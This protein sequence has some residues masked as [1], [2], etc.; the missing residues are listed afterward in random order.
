[1]HEGHRKR[2]L[3][4]LESSADSLQDHE[5][6]E[7]LLYLEVPRKNTNPLAH[8]L[9]SS[10]GS[11]DGV[12]HATYEQL[13]QVEGVGPETAAFLRCNAILNER[14][15]FNEDYF[16]KKFNFENYA[17]F[18]K[19]RFD[20]VT[21]EVVEVFAL[22]SSEHVISCKRFTS[23]SIDKASVD[24]NDLALLIS[25]HRPHGIVLAHNHPNAPCKSSSADDGFTARVAMLC[26]VQNIQLFDHMIVGNDGVYSY[27]LSRDLDA[28]KSAFHIETMMKE[29]QKS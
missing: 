28:F 12:F 10:F 17:P 29:K 4:R 27:F 1:M 14:M 11:I 23:G 6:F 19:E 2:M 16:P 8:R 25:T 3:K 18:L 5:L 26:S 13:L 15:R 20:G 24:V 9:L 7:I 21:R 22:D